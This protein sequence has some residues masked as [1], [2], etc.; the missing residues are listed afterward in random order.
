MQRV[1]ADQAVMIGAA[2]LLKAHAQAM[3]NAAAAM[4]HAGFV[5]R[6]HPQRGIRATGR[7]VGAAAGRKRGEGGHQLIGGTIW[8][9]DLYFNPTNG[10]G[11]VSSG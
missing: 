5:T 6:Q 8:P 7:G 9:L 2:D 1:V 11:N 10:S 3:A 4:A